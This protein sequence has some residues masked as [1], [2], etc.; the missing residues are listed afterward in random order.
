MCVSVVV[1]TFLKFETIFLKFES[2]CQHISENF[3]IKLKSPTLFLHHSCYHLQISATKVHTCDYNGRY[4]CQECHKKTLHLIPARVI[5]NWDFKPRQIALQ[6][7]EVI[8]Y[9]T[10]KEYL[11]IEN[12]NPL[13]FD[14][15]SVMNQLRELREKIIM[16]KAHFFQCSK[17]LR[18]GMFLKLK[19][20]QHFIDTSKLYTLRDL[21][22][23]NSGTLLPEVQAVVEGYTKHVQDCDTCTNKKFLCPVCEAPP[24]IS[25]FKDVYSI[26][27]CSQCHGVLH[28]P[29]FNRSDKCPYCSASLILEL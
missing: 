23:A 29:C 6:S 18:E 14:N 11:N 13:L 21:V 28:R 19:S 17:A 16:Y 12:L 20:R 22:E 2:N 9:L 3:H 15:V 1:P 27:Q 25:P 10:D 4:Y 7:Q 8:S 26:A 24:L 5:H